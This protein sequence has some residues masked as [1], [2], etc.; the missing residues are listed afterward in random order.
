LQATTPVNP[1]VGALT[2]LRCSQPHAVTL[3]CKVRKSIS[4]L[5]P[6]QKA[7]FTRLEIPAT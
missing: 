2:Q 5:T 3:G 6:Q 1:H 4:A 7:L